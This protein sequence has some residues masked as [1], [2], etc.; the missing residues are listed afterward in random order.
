MKPNNEINIT[1]PTKLWW[2]VLLWVL[3]VYLFIVIIQFK[4]E[5]NQNLLLAGLY[6]IQFGVHEASH[7]LTMFFSPVIT[8]LAGSIGEIGFTLIIVLA[9][10]KE[11]VYYTAIFGLLWFA[12]AMNSV[13]RYIADARAQSL[14]LIGP[15]ETVTHDWHFILG[16]WGLLA[17][18]T[19]IGS[20]VQMIGNVIGFLALCWGLWLIVN[21][22]RS[23][24]TTH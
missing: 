14:P 22:F 2:Y 1:I 21:H 20:T 10:L 11:R 15:G 6:F 3:Y 23:P 5:N 8:A 18:D 4:V 12:L 17:Q 7:I 16:E 13:G 19:A 9:A 24:K